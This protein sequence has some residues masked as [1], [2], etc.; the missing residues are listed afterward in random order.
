MPAVRV[1]EY[2]WIALRVSI[3]SQIRRIV[4]STKT[5]NVLYLLSF[6]NRQILPNYRVR[7]YPSTRPRLVVA[8]SE[9]VH[10]GLGVELLGCEPV[11][12]IGLAADLVHPGLAV[13]HPHDAARAVMGRA[14]RA[15]FSAGHYVKKFSKNKERLPY[16]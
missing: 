2:Y 4:Y 13:F 8:R 16:E 11:G 12:Q 7:T 6:Y 1:S 5:R 9:V 10:S 15:V 14:R 3:Q